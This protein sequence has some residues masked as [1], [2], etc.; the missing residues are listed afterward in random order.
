VL[1][2]AQGVIQVIL[3]NYDPDA[4]YVAWLVQPGVTVLTERQEVIN[5]TLTLSDL[6]FRQY[7]VF[8][9]RGNGQGGRSS[10]VRLVQERSEVTVRIDVADLPTQ[11]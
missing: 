8:V 6:P 11:D 7:D 3:E 9:S 2:P 1:Y 4:T 5:G 10:R